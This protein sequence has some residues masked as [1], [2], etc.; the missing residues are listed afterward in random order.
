MCQE[1]DGPLESSPFE[2]DPR[3]EE[4]PPADGVHCA[5]CRIQL[6]EPTGRF[7]RVLRSLVNGDQYYPR[8]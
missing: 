5:G 3:E 8:R 7:G 2:Y 4:A 6:A 1:C